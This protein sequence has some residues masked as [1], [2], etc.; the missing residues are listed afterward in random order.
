MTSDYIKL[1]EAIKNNEIEKFTE[2][3]TIYL[4]FR[5][6]EKKFILH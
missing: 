4:S 3:D 2:A 5:I 6:D 1:Y